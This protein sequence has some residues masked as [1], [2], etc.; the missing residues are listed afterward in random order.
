LE[1]HL[2]NSK[3]STDSM[4]VGQS[5]GFAANGRNDKKQQRN[6]GQK[7]NGIN[8]SRPLV[9]TMYHWGNVLII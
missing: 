2:L 8:D 5:P 4:P 9:S 6:L 7:K 3:D 1:D